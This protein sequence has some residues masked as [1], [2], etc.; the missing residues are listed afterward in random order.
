MMRKSWK[1]AL[2]AACVLSV[3]SS[4]AAQ[5]ASAISGGT[6]TMYLGAFPNRILVIDEATEQVVEEIPVSIGTPRSLTLSEDQSRFY[7]LSTTYEEL[8]IID[9]TTRKSIDTFTLSEGNRRVRIRGFRVH[10]AGDYA[11]LALDTAVKQVDR[12]E[13]E[14]RALVQ[15]SLTDHEI[16]R[17]IPWPNG[18]SRRPPRMLFSPDG[19]L[20]Y[21]F[22]RDVIVLET[23]TFTEVDRWA[24]SEP[25]EDGLG[26]LN[27]TFATDLRREEP[28][29][30]TGIFRMH[31]DVQDRDLMGIARF[32]LPG[33]DVDFY[34]LGPSVG[35]SFALAPGR[36]RAYGVSSE[37]GHYEFWAF[38][39]ENRRLVGRQS[40]DG[41][42]RMALEVSS[43]GRLLYIFQAGR[44]ID[45]YDAE[46]YDHLRTI[47]LDGDMTTDLIIFPG[48]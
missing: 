13:I 38:D 26:R 36:R 9:V 39:L 44:T 4:A 28:G 45:L 47:E 5:S 6:G 21:V 11:I 31:D 42:P 16:V 34:T 12:F 35:M 48:S 17:E 10:P 20:L 30:F 24:L 15:Y 43:N 7:I 40:F 27:F 33:R 37:I 8:E 46:S 32:D 2:V 19:D 14:P 1:D 3:A 22:D 29:F 41:R 25:I 23:G 18:Q